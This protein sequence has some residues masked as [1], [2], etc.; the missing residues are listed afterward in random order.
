MQQVSPMGPVYQAGT[1]SGNPL[2][3]AAGL[4]T[5]RLLTEPGVYSHLEALSA[6]LVEGLGAAA[7]AAGV[8]DVANRVGSMFTGFFCDGPVTEYAP[9]KRAAAGRYARSSHAMR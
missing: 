8:V 6:R 1:L 3:M 4:A 5:V 9:A 2:A 7:Q